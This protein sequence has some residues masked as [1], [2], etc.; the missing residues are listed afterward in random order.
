M[1]ALARAHPQALETVTLDDKYSLE[2]GRAFMSGIQ[3]LVEAADAAAPARCARRQN[4]ALVSSAATA[5]RRWAAM[6]RRCGRRASTWKG[7]NIVFQPGVN[8]ELAATAVWGTQQ[9]GFAPPGSNRFDGVFGIWYG[10]GPGWT[11]ASTCSTH[12]NMAGTTPWGG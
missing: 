10:K 5:A 4:T 1:N 3:A 2:H 6:T 11:A 8:E 12:A 7:Q 9:L